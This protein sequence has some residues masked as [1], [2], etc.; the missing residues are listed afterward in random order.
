[1][2]GG[3]LQLVTRWGIPLLTDVQIY[4]SH[5]ASM[6]LLINSLLA[7]FL[8]FFPFS[9][10]SLNVGSIFHSSACWWWWRGNYF[11][12]WF[13]FLKTRVNTNVCRRF[14]HSSHVAMV[15][16]FPRV[17]PSENGGMFGLQFLVSVIFL[18][19]AHKLNNICLFF[20]LSSWSFR[21]AHD[22][23]ALQV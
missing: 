5:C 21:G 22:E 20:V 23:R 6:Q 19:G 17:F 3:F 7:V 16:K 8:S 9:M 2:C 14:F 13:L 18:Y 1:M 11:H 10:I 15:Q 12:C 4:S